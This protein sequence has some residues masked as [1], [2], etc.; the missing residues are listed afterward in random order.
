MPTLSVEAGMLVSLRPMRLA[1]RM[2]VS[3]SAMGSVIMG[4]PGSLAHAGDFA[5]Q[6]ALAQADAADAELAVHRARTAADAAAAVSAHL[7]LRHALGLDDQAGL[8]HGSLR[9][10][11]TGQ[12]A[13]A[14]GAP[15]LLRKG[16][17]S[18]SSRA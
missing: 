16:M 12:P 2:R 13:R 5:A 3:M 17:P 9:S 14:V 15:S 4:S 1:L 8:G 10:W 7:E 18:S 6:R 11:W